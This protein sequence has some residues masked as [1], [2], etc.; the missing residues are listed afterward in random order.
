MPESIAPRKRKPLPAE[1]EASLRDGAVK[2]IT[3]SYFRCLGLDIAA[4]SEAV[5][6]A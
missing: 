2:I 5:E 6:R 3:S 1:T 4:D